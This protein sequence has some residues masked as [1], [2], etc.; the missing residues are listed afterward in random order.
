LKIF[1]LIAILFLSNCKLF[2]GSRRYLVANT[3]YSIPDGTPVFQQ[4]WRDGCENGLYS[5]GNTFYR[6]KYNG[7]QYSPDL[8]DNPEY[9]FGYGKAYSYCFTL[10]TAGEHSGG[11]DAFIYAKGAPFD[12]E[13]TSI[14][15]TVNYEVGSWSNAANVKHKGV[16]GNF[17]AIQSPKGFSVF[18]SHP[19]YGTTNEKQIFGW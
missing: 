11:F 9:K 10:N 16:D 15:R 6:T 1:L 18:G 13:R 17:D 8:M 3:N 12:M 7:F 4:G 14:D 5:R 19:L 2:T